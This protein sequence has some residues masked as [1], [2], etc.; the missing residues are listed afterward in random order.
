MNV[1]KSIIIIAFFF[2]FSFSQAADGLI[3]VKSPLTAKET[4]D[5][6]EEVVTN[7]GLQVFARINHQAG[8]ENV[9]KALRPTQVLVFGNPQGGTPLM[10]CAQT[11][12][13]D[14]PLKALVWEDANAQVWLGYNDLAYLADRHAVE[15]CPAVERINKALAALTAAA[16][17]L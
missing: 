4:M 3:K 9:G 14:L 16:V 15:T 12:G 8:A 6:F 17:E 7:K 1:F 5:K 13:I 11:L 10:Q 2:A